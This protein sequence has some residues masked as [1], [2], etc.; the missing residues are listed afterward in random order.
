M[1]GVAPQVSP[2]W[3]PNKWQRHAETCV[4]AN[5]NILNINPVPT[6]N[7]TKSS[8]QYNL[9]RNLEWQVPGGS[10]AALTRPALSIHCPRHAPLSR[11]RGATG[12]ADLC[13]SGH[14]TG[15]A[16]R[17]HHALRHAAEVAQV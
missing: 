12:P 15:A 10:A 5:Y 4:R 9:C 14:A 7:P 16:L 17:H 1:L 8:V 3:H 2:D 13:R 11:R 6:S